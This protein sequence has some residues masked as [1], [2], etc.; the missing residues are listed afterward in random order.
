MTNVT[1]ASLD[2]ILSLK[3]DAGHALVILLAA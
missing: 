2:S 1:V 3:Q